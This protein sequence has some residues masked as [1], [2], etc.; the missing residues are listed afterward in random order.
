MIG[1]TIGSNLSAP[2][3]GGAVA[4]AAACIRTLIVQRTLLPGDQMRQ[5][6]LAERIGIS[7]GPTR[8]ALG[9]LAAEGVLRY[10]SNRGYF[11]TRLTFND[12]SQVYRIRDLLETE[13]LMN[14]PPATSDVIAQLRDLNDRIRAAG[15]DL[16]LVIQLN[17]EFH[18][19]VLSLSA[20]TVLRSELEHIASLTTAYQSLSINMLD[21]WEL[22]AS[23][24]DR[25][26]A[27]L[28]ALD[29]EKLAVI[30]REHRDTSLKRLAPV[31]R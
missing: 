10:E 26:I 28:E 29:N 12:M 9:I 8:E 7:R 1:D 22:L 25:I 11:V 20:L 16:D 13:I 2:L 21:D 6:D 17:S 19:T 24:H 5:E 15:D 31:M 18:G 27:A 3:H 30:C 4:R 23:D 14:L